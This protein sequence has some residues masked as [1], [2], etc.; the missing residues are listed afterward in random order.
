MLTDLEARRLLNAIKELISTKPIIFPSLQSYITLEA[1][2]AQ[3]ND[4]FQID[5]HR[6][7]LNVKKCTYQ[8]RY[9]K[10]IN[11]LRIDIEGPP[12]PN[13]D[14]TEVPCPHIHIYREGYDDKWAYPLSDK[15]STDPFDL[16]QVLIDFLEYNN[17][18]NTPNV[19][20]QIEVN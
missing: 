12:H 2:S 19:I 6:K 16:V 3:T 1:T 9:K 20:S 17:I 15:I 5:V 7:T 18:N 11:L 10:S 13:P 4:K 8:T 14:G